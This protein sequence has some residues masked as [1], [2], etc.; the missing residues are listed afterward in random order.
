MAKKWDR[1]NIDELFTFV[2]KNNHIGL[3]KKL[4]EICNELKETP[5]NL[6]T[7]MVHPRRQMALL[8]R[9]LLLGH[10]ETAIDEDHKNLKSENP[11]NEFPMINLYEL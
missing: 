10:E 8:Q 3:L 1:F 2:G 11:E 9:A 6:A 7:K 4:A 5:E